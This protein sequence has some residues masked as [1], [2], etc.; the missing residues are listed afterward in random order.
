MSIGSHEL[1]LTIINDGKG[2]PRRKMAGE[3]L[4]NPAEPRLMVRDMAREFLAIALDGAKEYER[5]FGSPGASCFS[6]ADICEAA[7]EL[8]EYYV[9]HACECDRIAQEDAA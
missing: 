9:N 7:A 2:Y 4:L 5:Q 8:S 6:V 1:A 3:L